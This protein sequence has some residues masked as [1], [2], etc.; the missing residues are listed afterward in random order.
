M[1]IQS[2]RFWLYQAL[3]MRAL[4]PKFD[5]ITGKLSYESGWLNFLVKFEQDVRILSGYTEG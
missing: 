4:K 3:L 1:L 2:V 5:L